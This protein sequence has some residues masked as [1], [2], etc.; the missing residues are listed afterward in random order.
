MDRREDRRRLPDLPFLAQQAVLEV[1]VAAALAEPRAIAP[2]GNR[3]THHE[4][5]GPHLARRH[6]API[7]ARAGEAARQHDLLAE[8]LRIDLD[9]TLL[10][11]EA[12]HGHVD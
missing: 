9:E 11:P 10:G 5:D 2:D 1:A 6:R 12:R 4:I 8:T 7:A 3:A